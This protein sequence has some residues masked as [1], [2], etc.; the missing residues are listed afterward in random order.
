M[1][2]KA[3]KTNMEFLSYFFVKREK[4]RLVKFLFY[5]FHLFF[6]VYSLARCPPFPRFSSLR[7][8]ISFFPSIL[9]FI[10]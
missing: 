7:D 6:T 10:H 2:T 4:L 9:F 5:N 8:F 3:T 1:F